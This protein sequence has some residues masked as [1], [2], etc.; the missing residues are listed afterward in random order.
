MNRAVWL[1]ELVMELA[2][3]RLVSYLHVCQENC[4]VRD[5]T[6]ILRLGRARE[7]VEEVWLEALSILR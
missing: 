5:A 3:Y 7:R 6:D 1:E 4:R 2:S